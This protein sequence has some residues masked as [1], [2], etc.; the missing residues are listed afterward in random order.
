MKFL[1]ASLAFILLASTHIAG[2]IPAHVQ[3]AEVYIC[4]SANAKAYHAKKECKGLDA[5]THTIKKVTE[6]EA[7]NDYNRRACKVCYK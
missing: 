3:T 4:L 6:K 7:I 5:C 2:N 1:L